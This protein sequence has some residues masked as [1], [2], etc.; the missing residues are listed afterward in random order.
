MVVPETR[1]RARSLS[2][3]FCIAILSL[4]QRTSAS[5]NNADR[6]AKRVIVICIKGFVWLKERARVRVSGT[7]ISTT[8]SVLCN[9]IHISPNSC[10]VN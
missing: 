9:Q 5:S 10:V 1:T 8:Q 7:T 3:T 2:H 4:L 6:K